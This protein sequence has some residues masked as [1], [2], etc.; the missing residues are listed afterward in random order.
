[1]HNIA[2]VRQSVINQT[3]KSDEDKQKS[4]QMDAHLVYVSHC[5]FVGICNTFPMR[6]REEG[7]GGRGKVYPI[8]MH[9]RST[10]MKDRQIKTT[11]TVHASMIVKT[12]R[13]RMPDSHSPV[14][15]FK[16]LHSITK[17]LYDR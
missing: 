5:I 4:P 17:V 2:C 10:S 13:T 8:P 3:R 14:L 7:P 11:E 1:M 9:R 15:S 6:G 16:R 12:G